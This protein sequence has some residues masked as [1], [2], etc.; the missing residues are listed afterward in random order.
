MSEGRRCRK[1][2]VHIIFPERKGPYFAVAPR[3]RPYRLLPS[4]H[5]AEIVSLTDLL[6][7]SLLFVIHFLV[8]F[9]CKERNGWEYHPR[10]KQ[11]H[12]NFCHTCEKR[13]MQRALQCFCLLALD[14]M[15]TQRPIVYLPQRFPPTLFPVYSFLSLFNFTPSLLY[16]FKT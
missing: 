9:V 3:S 8:D 7:Y 13:S 12:L 4:S 14:R 15:N 5:R 11:L 1:K 16:K 6:L 10:N 2:G